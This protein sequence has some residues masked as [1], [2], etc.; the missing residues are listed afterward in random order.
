MD[1]V[2]RDQLLAGWRFSIVKEWGWTGTRGSVIIYRVVFTFFIKEEVKTRHC[3][4][5]PTPSFPGLVEI[6]HF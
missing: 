1:R 2:D 3:A 5:L 4:A 6:D